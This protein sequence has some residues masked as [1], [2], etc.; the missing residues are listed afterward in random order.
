MYWAK[1]EAYLKLNKIR[2][3]QP[4]MQKKYYKQMDVPPRVVD[5]AKSGIYSIYSTKERAYLE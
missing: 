5:A 3:F 4:N 1:C 2:D